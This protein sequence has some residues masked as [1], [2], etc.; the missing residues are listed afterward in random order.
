MSSFNGRQIEMLVDAFWNLHAV[1]CPNDG[2]KIQARLYPQLAGYLLVLGCPRCG[3]KAQITHYSDPRRAA[4]RKW[5]QTEGSTLALDHHRGKNVNCPVCMARV[6]HRIV[7]QLIHVFECPRCGNQHDVLSLDQ[8]DEEV[9][10]SRPISNPP[11]TYEQRMNN[12]HASNR[13][14][15]QNA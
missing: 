13:R 6:K 3:T 8:A 9:P 2:A 14:I 4:F 10:S 5:T 7:G 1:Q 11:E 15:A 12:E